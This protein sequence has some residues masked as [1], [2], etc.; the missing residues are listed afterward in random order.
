MNHSES[1][2]NNVKQIYDMVVIG[3]GPAGYTAA[4]YAA[5]AGMSVVVIE[6]LSAGGQ[7][8]LTEQ[9][10]N[11]PG[12]VYGVDGIQCQMH[13]HTAHVAVFYRFGKS[14]RCKIFRALAGIETAAAQIYRVSTVLNGSFQGFH[15]A[16]GRQ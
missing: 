9:I 14:L 13:L 15:R 8:A 10:D 2:V 12:F 4:L 1:K 16:G 5:R 7:M 11:Y 6:K 3:G